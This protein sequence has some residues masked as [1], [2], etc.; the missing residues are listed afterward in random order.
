M[1]ATTCLRSTGANSRQHRSY[2]LLQAPANQ[3]MEW[4]I[5]ATPDGKSPRTVRYQPLASETALLY[6]QWWPTIARGSI[7]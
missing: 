2:E 5:S 1:S 7:R 3:P 4:R 6:L